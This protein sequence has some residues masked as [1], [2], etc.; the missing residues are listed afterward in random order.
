MNVQ[1]PKITAVLHLLASLFVIGVF[2]L[3]WHAAE[4]AATVA[5]EPM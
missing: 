4:G 2:G 5:A 3:L 1:P